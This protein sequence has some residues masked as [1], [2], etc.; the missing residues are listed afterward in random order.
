MS[1]PPVRLGAVHVSSGSSARPSSSAQ[2]QRARSTRT[3]TPGHS[4]TRSWPACSPPTRSRVL[5]TVPRRVP[6]SCAATTAT[7]SWASTPPNTSSSKMATP[8]QWLKSRMRSMPTCKPLPSCWQRIARASKRAGQAQKDCK[9][10]KP[11]STIALPMITASPKTTGSLCSA[12]VSRVAFTRASRWLSAKSSAACPTSP[13]RWAT[14]RWK[15]PLPR[16]AS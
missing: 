11:K 12:R 8:R 3:W 1:T 14:R 4:T 16:T 15:I 6:T 5:P 13:T 10:A 7:R 9:A 2:P